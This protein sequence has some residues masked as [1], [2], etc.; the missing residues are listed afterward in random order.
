MTRTIDREIKFIK[1]ALINY[2]TD[3]LSY[4]EKLTIIIID[5]DHERA[6]KHVDEYVLISDKYDTIISD[7]IWLITKESPI[8]KDLRK[9]IAYINI[10]RDC[11]RISNLILDIG[12]RFI[13]YYYK[14][15]NYFNEFL[16]KLINKLIFQIKESIEFI[17]KYNEESLSR[18]IQTENLINNNCNSLLINLNKK[19]QG[20]SKDEIIQLT[21]VMGCLKNLEWCAD[22]CIQFLREKIFIYKN[23]YIN[24]S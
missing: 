15:F 18:I 16:V 20:A 5:N 24:L 14:S 21:T 12:K 7:I 23:R 3:V 9:M 19:L 4:I 17:K 22:L 1:K 11:Y 10:F 6:E 2:M 13:K 8:A